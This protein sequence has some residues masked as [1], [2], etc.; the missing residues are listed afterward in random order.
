MAGVFILYQF[1]KWKAQ[2]GFFSHS[3]FGSCLVASLFVSSCATP[4]KPL[5]HRYGYSEQ[6]VGN[7]A[8]EVTFLGNGNSSYERAFDLAMLRAAE[9]AL[10]RQAKSFTLLDSVSLGSVRKYRTPTHYYWTASPYLSTGG[11]TI[12][13]APEFINGT[14]RR[15]LMMDPAGER[16]YYRPGVKL[17]VKLLP[18]PAGGDY[19]YAP[20]KESERLKRKYRIKAGKR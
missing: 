6:Q 1:N 7:D 5:E 3:V 13:S 17:K 14:E 18:D 8:F 11:E 9:I 4:Y 15:Y 10:S 19:S 20:A 2:R 12:P 16:I